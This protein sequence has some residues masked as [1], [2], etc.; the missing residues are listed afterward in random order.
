MATE[1]RIHAVITETRQ[2]TKRGWDSGATAAPVEAESVVV[3]RNAG[4]F[5]I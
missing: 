2:A 5:V 1:E 3:P 4:Q